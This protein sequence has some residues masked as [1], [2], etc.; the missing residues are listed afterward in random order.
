VRLRGPA[1]VL[2]TLRSGP[3]RL[4]PDRA[5]GRL[6]ERC[7]ST[8]LALRSPLRTSSASRVFSPV[9]RRPPPL[10]SDPP[11]LG[12]SAPA[13]LPARGV[14]V[15]APPSR[16]GSLR[17]ARALPRRGIPVPRRSAS[18]VSHGPDGLLLPEPGGVFRP[19]TPLGF[20]SPR[21]P[22]ALSFQDGLTTAPSGHGGWA[23]VPQVPG[24]I[25]H[26]A[27][28][29]G[30]P[31][32]R[33]SRRSALSRRTS[34]R[35]LPPRTALG[36]PRGPSG[37]ASRRL[38]DARLRLPLRLPPSA[39]ALPSA[40]LSAAPRP[41]APKRSATP[42]SVQPDGS[43]C[44]DHR[45]LTEVRLRLPL[46]S[47]VRV[48]VR[49]PPAGL[50]RRSVGDRAV[51]GC[52]GPASATSPPRPVRFRPVSGGAPAALPTAAAVSRGH[53]RVPPGGR[54]SRARLRSR[55]GNLSTPCPRASAGFTAAAGHPF[56][57]GRASACARPAAGHEDSLQ[58]VKEREFV[59]EVRHEDL[60]AHVF[61][62]S[63]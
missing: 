55:P 46:P 29:D 44:Q 2:S 51:P 31:P 45:F 1:S 11:P 58:P 6:P 27:L 37:L 38:P 54:P 28:R 42:A 4:P 60:E 3:W 5:T 56:S 15:P 16:C 9:R 63:P 48:R 18:A 20:A 24:S 41:F 7:G 39:P 26:Q 52:P 61:E 13:A 22:L 36:A 35:C 14:R 25:P 59:I 34:C 23:P 8:L 53:A 50:R 49:W 47:A 10:P 21:S 40:R 62:F 57:R 17:R 30:A 32:A 43:P 19:L 33:P 12:F